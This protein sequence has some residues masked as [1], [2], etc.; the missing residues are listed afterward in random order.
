MTGHRRGGRLAERHVLGQS[1]AQVE[2][3]GDVAR[4]EVLVEMAQDVGIVRRGGKDVDETEQLRLERRMRHRPLEHAF[5]P[6]RRVDD[7]RALPR[8]Q[9]GDPA[10]QG[11][12]LGQTTGDRD[13][14]R[15]AWS[16]QTVSLG[17]P[18]TGSDPLA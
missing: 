3:P 4:L 5:A 2:H 11:A 8:A 14:G 1:Q 7:P 18:S 12:S 17:A 15:I 10:S 13:I 6:P 16:R 9:L